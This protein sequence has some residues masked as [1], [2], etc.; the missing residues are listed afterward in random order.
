ME[1]VYLEKSKGNKVNFKSPFLFTIPL[2]VY[3]NEVER[4]RDKESFVK[5]Q[6]LEKKCEQLRQKLH[7]YTQQHS[8][9]I[10]ATKHLVLRTLAFNN[11][12]YLRKM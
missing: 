12:M 5:I 7:I 9:R 8:M 11:N 3:S 4:Q 6:Q 2:N 10:E 1:N